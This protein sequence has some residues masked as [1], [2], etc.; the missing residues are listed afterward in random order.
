MKITYDI[1]WVEDEPEKIQALKNS[2]EAYL[3]DYGIRANV[4]LI[5]SR[6][7]LN[8]YESLKMDLENPNLDMIVVDYHMPSMRGDELVKIIR[9]SNH[10]FLPVIF[11]SSRN[12]EEVY[13]SVQNKKLDG[14]YIV[15]R[16]MFQ[17]KFNAVVKSLLYK[18]HS[19]KHTR[20]LLM[21]EISEFDSLLKEVFVR[22]LQ[23]MTSEQKL[24][25]Q[26]YVRK[27]AKERKK[28]AKR[29]ERDIPDEVTEFELAMPEKLCTMM[30]DTMLRWKIIR[31]VLG[32]N[33]IDKNVRDVFD[34]FAGS[35]KQHHTPLNSI[36]NQY[37]HRTRAELGEEHTEEKCIEIRKEIGVQ[38]KNLEKILKHLD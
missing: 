2:A 19:I 24:Q 16:E 23:K 26:S 8:L 4:T 17:P 21:E 13:Q 11:Y 37:A 35:S 29:L 1:L 34:R 25:L 36:R 7:K 9:E 14:V 30:F 15:A 22:G 18:E 20:G 5:N 32:Y 6:G 10:I 12:I 33:Q 3:N 31:R 28:R 27:L 38:Q